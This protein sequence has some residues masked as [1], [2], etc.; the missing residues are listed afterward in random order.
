MEFA[1][2][3]LALASA[4]SIRLAN[5]LPSLVSQLS[6]NKLLV[7]K[8]GIEVS[9]EKFAD[10]N[11]P[12]IVTILSKVSL[13]M[14][15]QHAMISN[16]VSELEGVKML[17]SDMQ[18]SINTSPPQLD[19][20]CYPP[21]SQ[22]N[23]PQPGTGAHGKSSSNNLPGISAINSRRPL[24]Q[25]LLGSSEPWHNV[26]KRKN[27]KTRAETVVSQSEMESDAETAIPP[28]K[29]DPFA[30]AV[31]DAEKSI[32]I[33]NLNLGQSP[34]L[35]PATISSKITAALV[36]CVA[37]VDP[38]AE[39]MVTAGVKDTIDDIIGLVKNMTL[40]GSGTRPNRNPLNPEGNGKFYTVPVKFMFA[41]KQVAIRVTEVLKGRYKLPVTTP[42]HKSL[43]ACFTHVQK[44]VR[45]MNP[46]YQVR[47]NLDVKNRLLKASV[48]PA[49]KAPWELLSQTFPLPP[50][51]LD[52]KYQD[53]KSM[54]FGTPTK[55]PPHPP[56]V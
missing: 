23:F 42:Y 8:I 50:E 18:N 52:P 44:K 47:V 43:R 7:D 27:R 6:D 9:D 12:A 51:A 25:A 35:N 45:S 37:Q 33:H 30:A 26:E 39:G 15:A 16:V 36:L 21:L 14:T 29:A 34:T 5:S 55:S 13:A 24:K 19:P 49:D 38:L 56:L 53:V 22:P 46:G 17:I 31:K 48:R 40:F 28:P 54:V 4:K 10:F 1:L 20:A 2:D 41:S 3:N 32:L 11:D